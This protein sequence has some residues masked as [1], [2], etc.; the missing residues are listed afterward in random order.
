MQIKIDMS[1]LNLKATLLASLFKDNTVVNCLHES[2][3]KTM[4]PEILKNI[5]RNRT[6]WRGAL[7]RSIATK[8]GTTGGGVFSRQRPSVTLGSFGLKYAAAIEEGGRPHT[9]PFQP[10][11][12]WVVEKVGAA[13]PYAFTKAVIRTIEKQGTK[14]YP[15]VLPAVVSQRDEMVREFMFCLLRQITRRGGK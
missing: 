4:Q 13:D 15:F 11:Y 3:K 7:I 10:I 12:Q 14:S 2:V 8:K 6:M 5:R 1:E 9:P